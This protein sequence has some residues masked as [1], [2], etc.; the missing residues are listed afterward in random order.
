[1]NKVV[2]LVAGTAAAATMAVVGAGQAF[3]SGPAPDVTGET[4]ASA[5]AILQ[6]AGYSAVFGGSVGSDLPQSQ[7][8]VIEG[9]QQGG[10]IWSSPWGSAGTVRLRLDCTLKA[11]QTKPPAPGTLS[12]VAPSAAPGAAAGGNNENNRPTPG[13]GTVTVTPVPVG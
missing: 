8:V 2:L 10:G 4:Y 6:S 5:Q 9:K 3:A 12:R 11:G 7:C 13:A 1:V